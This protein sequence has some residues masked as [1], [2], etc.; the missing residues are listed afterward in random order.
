MRDALAGSNDTDPESAG[1]ADAVQTRQVPDRI[2]SPLDSEIA[3]MRV[4][5]AFVFLS[6]VAAGL[7]AAEERPVAEKYLIS[8]DLSGGQEALRAIL[9]D[10]P[11]DAQARFGLGTVQ[12]VGSV[13]RL[14]Q[15]FY[16]HGLQAD[17]SGGMIPFARL[18]V[19]ANPKPEPIAYDDLRALFRTFLDDLARAEGTLALVKDDGV[20]L[21]IRFGLVRLDLDGDG[22]ATD[23]ETLWKLYARLNG[24]VARDK[25]SGNQAEGFPITFDR[26]DVAWLRGYCHLLMAFSEVFLA[27]DASRLF[28]HT[29]HLFFAKPRTPFAFLKG[30]PQGI[31]PMGPNGANT[32][33]IGDLVAFVHL[34][35]FPVKEPARMGAALGH[36]EAMVTLSRESWK[37]YLAE[38]DDDHEW[39]P[40]PKQET[41]MPGGKVTDEMVKSWLDFLGEADAILAG[42]KLVP[43]WR[44]EDKKGVNLRR[45]FTEPAE[46]DLILWVQGTAAAPYLEAG[47]VT[48]PEVWTRLLR[49][50]RGEFIG[51]ALWFN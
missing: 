40:N 4:A 38:T 31:K 49:V 6:T 34:L 30:D 11:E 16:K 33:T 13:E 15:G 23:E 46:M 27:H 8:G 41:V 22:K 42:K 10:H 25:T 43:F 18:P 19:P 32:G 26:G 48:Q 21:P 3:I 36:L 37:F 2:P 39:I 20:K 17:L 35:H 44:D 9:K 28:D 24:Q 29:A 47:T 50:F 5:L 14:I 45:V 1:V 7:P 12:F 51:F